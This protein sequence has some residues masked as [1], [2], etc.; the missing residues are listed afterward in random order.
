VVQPINEPSRIKAQKQK[1]K[2][3]NQRGGRRRVW[4]C[5]GAARPRNWVSSKQQPQQRFNASAPLQRPLQQA[6]IRTSSSR[7]GRPTAMD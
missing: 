1:F 5:A 7:S 3:K 4:V 6:K 2:E